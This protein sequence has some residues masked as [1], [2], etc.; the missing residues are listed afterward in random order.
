MAGE[1]KH[2]SFFAGLKTEMNRINSLYKAVYG[3]G[4]NE[5]T[6]RT[7]TSLCLTD[8]LSWGEEKEIILASAPSRDFF[9]SA[10]ASAVY[11]L[12]EKEEKGLDCNTIFGLLLIAIYMSSYQQLYTILLTIQR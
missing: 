4:I 12:Q 5:P 2:T 7:F 9:L 11:S 8:D 10:A 1:S 6:A 3:E